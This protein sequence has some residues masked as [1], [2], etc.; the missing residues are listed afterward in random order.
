[1]AKKLNYRDRYGNQ[2][3]N[4][5][6][7]IVSINISLIQQEAVI[8]FFGYKDK[9]AY[10]SGAAPLGNKEYVINGASFTAFYN[11]HLAPGGPNLFQLAYAHATSTKDVVTDPA[12]ATKN[13]SFFANGE[14]V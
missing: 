1:M 13:V 2:Q 5:Y 8:L 6:W 10:D 12:D 9:Q 4:S 3:P 14:D 7:R 11:S